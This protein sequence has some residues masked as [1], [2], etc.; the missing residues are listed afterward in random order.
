MPAIVVTTWVLL[1]VS[2]VDA[3]V[4]RVP[5][6]A[7]LAVALYVMAVSEYLNSRGDRRRGGD[8]RSAS[9]RRHA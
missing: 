1:L 6:L 3:G 2:G 9:D 5:M 8:R 4:L 7:A